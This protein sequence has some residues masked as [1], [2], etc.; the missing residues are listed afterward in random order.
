MRVV[1]IIILFAISS[2]VS[3]Q[4]FT[5]AQST[6]E[7]LKMDSSLLE[8]RILSLQDQ[9]N[10]LGNKSASTEQSLNNRLQEKEDSLAMK[11]TLLQLR[12]AHILDMKSRQTDEEETFKQL[13]K[14]ITDPF[15]PF[16][17]HEVQTE[18][19]CSRAI[20]DVNDKLLFLPLST[21][22]ENKA[23]KIGASI[24]EVLSKNQ[25]LKLIII[26]YTDST[27]AGKEKWEDNWALGSAKSNTLAKWLIKN[28]KVNPSRIIPATQA[29][30][31]IKASNQS[32]LTTPKTSFVFYSELIPCLYI[33]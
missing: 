12:E 31:A 3:T 32:T 25:D 14:A 6:I 4:Q 10:Y 20:I 19:R 15:L 18:I 17:S 29:E 13:T 21:K 28:H 1:L 9:V 30:H 11:E 22:L 26:T 27:Y 24:A 2:C 8:K 7:R 16:A 23:D 33:D 5:R